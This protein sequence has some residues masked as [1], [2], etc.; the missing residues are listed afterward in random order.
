MTKCH[1]FYKGCQKV[2]VFFKLTKGF[3]MSIL[4]KNAETLFERFE[5]SVG[6]WAEKIF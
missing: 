6:E 3:E 5:N 4:I 1:I 2:V